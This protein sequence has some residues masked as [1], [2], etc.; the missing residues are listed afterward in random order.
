M[1]GAAFGHLIPTAILETNS[2]A[3]PSRVC[4]EIDKLPA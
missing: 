4:P 3:F 1:T 2:S